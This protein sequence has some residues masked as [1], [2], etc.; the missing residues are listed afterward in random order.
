MTQQSK[1]YIIETGHK[2]YNTMLYKWSKRNYVEVF[3]N[4][5]W[6]QDIDINI[7]KTKDQYDKPQ[8][9][10]YE[11]VR[12]VIIEIFN[13]YYNSTLRFIS[14]KDFENWEYYLIKESKDWIK[15]EAFSK[16]KQKPKGSIC[17]DFRNSLDQLWF[18]INSSDKQRRRQSARKN[19]TAIS[20]EEFKQFLNLTM[21]YLSDHESLLIYA[22]KFIDSFKK[23]ANGEEAKDG[24]IDVSAEKSFKEIVLQL[25]K[26]KNSIQERLIENDSDSKNSRLQLRGELEGIKF[27]LKTIKIHR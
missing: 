20:F 4:Y 25:E 10:K 13:D 23:L 27:A 6:I 2:V 3:E 14:R 1:Y 5:E 15:V 8:S 7:L 16:D 9:S 11:K 19:G 24:L 22:D 26:R 12:P 21:K 17:L 18:S